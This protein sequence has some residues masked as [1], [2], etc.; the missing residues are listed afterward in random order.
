M[1]LLLFA[2]PASPW[3][4]DEPL[5]FQALG[6][7]NPVA[8][9]PPPPGYPVFIFTAKIFRLVIPSDFAALVTVSVLSSAVAF[10]LLAVAFG[11]LAGDQTAGLVGAILFYLS[12]TMLIHS[13]LPVS[14]P[15]ALA[16]LSAALYFFPRPILFALFAALAVGWRIQFAIFV[17]PLFLVAVAMLPR[18]RDRLIA[19]GTFTLVCLIWLTPLTLAVGGVEKLIEFETKQAGY[20]AAHD[21]DESRS[22]WTAPRIALRF[23]AHPWGTKITAVPLLLLALIGLRRARKEFIPLGVAGAVYIAFALWTMDPAD[24]ARY[25]IPFMIVVA[26]LAGLGATM[27]ARPYLIAALFAIGSLIYVSSLLAQRSTLA[28]PPV[29]AAMYAKQVYPQNAVALYELALWPHATY[30]LRDHS[31]QRVDVGLA[32]YAARPDVPMFIYA[33]G[34]AD[35]AAVFRWWPSDAYQ[36]LTRNHYRVASIIPVNTRYRVVKGVFVP[37]REPEGMSWRWIS[38]AGE[39]QLPTGPVRTLSLTIGLPVIYPFESNELTISVDGRVAQVVKLE[40]ARE[41][42]VEISV[43]AGSPAIG[44]RAAASFIPAE[45]PGSLNRDRR[46][47]SVKIYR[48]ETSESRAARRAAS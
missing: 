28:S 18:W 5:F 45:M 17:V 15:G 46:R 10:F 6:D 14:E 3:E 25:S 1:V 19:L 35:D 8:H 26:F 29:R 2:M 44:F 39:I 37:E 34:A 21:A 12:P 16:L 31:P 43:P 48:I 9:H 27:L 33:D 22:G 36:K 24:G 23:I 11:K 41:T 30:Y 20:L 4:F 40:R 13:T 42:T 7:Y 38:D 32:A 47:L